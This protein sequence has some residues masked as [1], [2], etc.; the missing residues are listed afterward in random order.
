MNN[1]GTVGK[2]NLSA[3][4]LIDSTNAVIIY[5]VLVV[6]TAGGATSVIVKD[7][8]SSGT[9]VAQIDTSAAS[10]GAYIDLA[11]GLPLNTAGGGYITFDAN[12]SYVT[13][14]YQRIG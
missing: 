3:S 10:K 1:P 5:S 13:V 14:T 12:T 7:G 9:A 8:G 4:G 6:A 2:K 11:N